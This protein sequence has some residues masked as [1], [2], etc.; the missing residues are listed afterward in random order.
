MYL[1]PQISLPVKTLLLYLIALLCALPLCA[2]P[3]VLVIDAGHGGKDPGAVG[4]SHREK[5]FNLAV[6][7]RLGRLVEDSCEDVQVIYTRRTDTF[8]EL[9]ERAQIANRAKAD[10]FLSIHTNAAL[11]ASATGTET[12]ALGLHR[13]ADN[14]AVA[15][16]ENSVIS[17][18]ADADERY[19]GFD[20]KQAESY[21]VFEL[22]QDVN[23]KESIRMA[24]CVQQQYRRSGCTSRGVYQAGFLVLRAT[25]MPSILTEIGYISNLAEETR[26][27]TPEG[28]QQI[29]ESIFRGFIQYKRTKH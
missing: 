18:E 3:F 9:S 23:L 21:I 16:R 1:C 19:M 7:L 12:Y 17:M 4:R 25:S 5:D 27:A 20:P 11:N 15:M 24:S 29:A 28:Q 14:L 8:V 22:M 6:A 2:K 13:T 26:L 10:L